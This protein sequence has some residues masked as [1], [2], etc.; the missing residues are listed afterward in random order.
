M[1]GE[2]GFAIIAGV[3]IL[4]VLSALGAFMLH[5]SGMQHISS[6]W[7][8]Q[9]AQA[10]QAAHAGIQWG[11]QRVNATAAYNFSYGSPAS[12][13]DAAG[14]NLRAC[15]AAT[16]SFTLPAATLS[17][18]TVTVTC[19]ATTDANG[20]PTVYSLTATACNQAIS[21]WTATTTACPNA[22]NPGTFYVE[23]QIGITF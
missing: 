11:L 10:Y 1:R 19:T 4:V 13:V 14:P 17:G 20:G 15:P 18:F 3:F 16:S 22:T 23:R 8:L 12:A 7:D 2:R 21:G 9:G 5:I 6:A